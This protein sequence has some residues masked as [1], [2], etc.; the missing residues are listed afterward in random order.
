MTRM[1]ARMFALVGA[2]TIAVASCA[3]PNDFEKVESSAGGGAGS[4][5]ATDCSVKPE[6]PP[7]CNG[8]NPGIDDHCGPGNADWCCDTGCVPGGNFHRR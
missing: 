7:S 4:G 2:G 3:F 8:D 6:A 1:L 5:G